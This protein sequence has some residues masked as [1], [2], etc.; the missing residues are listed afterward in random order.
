MQIE[1]C[2][3]W[4][5]IGPSSLFSKLS[6]KLFSLGFIKSR[7][8]SSL[9]IFRNASHMVFVLIY[10]DDILIT[11]SSPSLI[12]DFILALGVSFPLKNLR[13]L[14]YF[15]G[16]EVIRNGH[17]LFLC[18]S[19]YITNFLH[20]TNMSQAKPVSTSTKLSP[21]DGSTFEDSHLYCSVIG[22]LQYLAFT[23]LVISFAV[24]NMS[25]HAFSSVI[26]LAGY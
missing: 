5:Q 3:L 14:H 9:F 17:G 26:S 1:K 22:S 16:I 4:S 10:V 2:N 11:G 6:S 13:H 20:K 24:N 8:D 7:S 25:I 19:K 23:R 18:Q 15:L 12:T 21:L